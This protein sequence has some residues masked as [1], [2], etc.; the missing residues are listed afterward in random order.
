M[1]PCNHFIIVLVPAEWQTF[2]STEKD[3]KAV[4]LVMLLKGGQ[5]RDVCAYFRFMKSGCPM[6]ASLLCGSVI[7]SQLLAALL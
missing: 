2:L 3:M 7:S 5:R 1:T 6:L 4:F